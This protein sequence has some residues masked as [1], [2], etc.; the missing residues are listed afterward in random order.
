NFGSA[1]AQLG[2]S[3]FSRLKSWFSGV[4][5]GQRILDWLELGSP[6]SLSLNL[7]YIHS[8]DPL[9][10]G[11]FQFVLIGDR[12]DRALYDHLNSYTGEDGSD[13]VVRI[14]AANLNA[15]HA[16]LS[17]H[18]VTDSDSLVL[19]LSRGPRC[20][21][22]LIAGASHSGDAHGIMAQATRRCAMHSMPK[23]PRATPTRWNWN[24]PARSRRACTS[25]TRAAC[26]SC[27][28]PTRRAS[29]WPVPASCSPRAPR[30]APT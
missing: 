25:T 1:L 22:K 29:R 6:A 28:S 21:F 16:V 27:G 3:V 9:A 10:R 14:A 30:P 7:D 19:N 8:E 26:S 11:Q 2:K 5:P 15:R 17:P 13:G 23:T 4:E 20:A 24:R 18:A 12:P